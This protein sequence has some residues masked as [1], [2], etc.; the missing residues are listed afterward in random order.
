MS[1]SPVEQPIKP[2]RQ[3]VAIALKAYLAQD[4]IENI[5]DA[6]AALMTEVEKPLLKCVMKFTHDNQSRAAEILGLSRGTLRKKL[7]EY[8]LL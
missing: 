3:Q 1:S 2:F 5:T 8:Q 4:N 6:Y 7:K